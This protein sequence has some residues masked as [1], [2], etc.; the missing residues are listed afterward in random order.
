[1][2]AFFYPLKRGFYFAEI[3]GGKVTAYTGGV[4]NSLGTSSPQTERSAEGYGI[5][6][7]RRLHKPIVQ[8]ILGN[9]PWFFRGF[10]EGSCGGISLFLW[11]GMFVWRF[12]IS[13]LILIY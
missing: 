8:R 4:R 6:L 11:L 12:S 1:M 9:F 13:P 3:Q 5:A 2:N 10:P 7:E